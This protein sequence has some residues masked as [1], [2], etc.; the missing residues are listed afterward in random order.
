MAD[1]Y[2]SEDGAVSLWIGQKLVTP[3]SNFLRDQF[4]VNYYDPDNQECIVEVAVTPISDL[5]SRLSFSESFRAAAIEAAERL[6]VKSALWV[7]AQFDFAYNPLA[8]GLK[9]PRSEPLFIGKFDWHE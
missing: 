1:L 7:M 2:L 8:A 6:G 9:S 5:V 4:G 3:G